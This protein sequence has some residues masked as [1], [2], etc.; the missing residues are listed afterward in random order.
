MTLDDSR[1]HKILILLVLNA[2]TFHS[3]KAAR[4]ERLLGWQLVGNMVIYLLIALYV[5]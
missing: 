2:E 3:H 5:K 4:G 1:D